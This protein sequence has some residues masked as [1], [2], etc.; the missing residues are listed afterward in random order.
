MFVASWLGV[1]SLAA[2]PGLAPADRD[3]VRGM[4]RQVRDDVIA[5][6]Y[7]PSFHGIDL[8]ARFDAAERRLRSAGTLADA[9]ALVSDVLFQLDDSHTLL[10]PPNR[11]AR[12][13]YGWHM[14]I[15]GDVPLVTSVEPDS[16]AAA[17]G[18]TPGDRVL[19][20]NALSPSRANISRLAYFY[21]FI[22]PEVRQRVS[23]LK[24]NGA[25]RTVDVVS[26]VEHAGAAGLGN[27]LDDIGDLLDRARDRSAP[28][29]DG[30]LVWRM[31]VFGQP[32]SV[33][34]MIATA[35]GYRTLVLDLRGNGGGSLDALRELVSRCFDREVL[36]ASE[37]RRGRDTREVAKPARQRFTG[38][39][40]VL[41]DSRSAS[42]TE[43]FAR[44]VQIEKRGSVIGDRTAGAVMTSRVFPHEIGKGLV[45]PYA[46]SI[47]VG[48]VRMSDGGSL[49]NVGVEPDEIALP[50]P[51]DLAA[52]RDPVL[53]RAIELAGGRLT[54][55]EAGRLFK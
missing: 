19:L 28:A 39:L 36:V 9:F 38:R 49:E 52:G 2:Q 25:A 53:A 48:D 5:N 29:G 18:L 7:D 14:A 24:P 45:S 32:R 26:R 42:A 47:T 4:L 55:D 44:I 20:L 50:T 43:M 35:R 10:I 51:L 37:R 12:V 30:V 31:A 11:Q 16:D 27:L 34:R 13:D 6:Y 46:V 23:V 15:V 17:K 1:V 8:R 21:R 3:V 54:P 40:V 41:V 33:E 22:R